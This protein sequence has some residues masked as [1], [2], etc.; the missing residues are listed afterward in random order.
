MYAELKTNYLKVSSFKNIEGSKIWRKDNCCW[1]LPAAQNNIY[2]VGYVVAS[3]NKLL[4]YIGH[5]PLRVTI[6]VAVIDMDDDDSL[7]PGLLATPASRVIQHVF[8]TSQWQ[9]LFMLFNCRPVTG[10]LTK[11]LARTRTA[12]MFANTFCTFAQILCF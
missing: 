10:R 12:Q 2:V 3:L 1:I 11:S 9:H 5:T 4:K 8:T 7:K 6:Y